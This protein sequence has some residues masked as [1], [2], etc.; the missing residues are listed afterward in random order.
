MIRDEVSRLLELQD[1][2]KFSEEFGDGMMTPMELGEAVRNSLQ[3]ISKSSGISYNG[4]LEYANVFMTELNP[5]IVN[6]TEQEVLEA[7]S[8]LIVLKETYGMS[9]N[10]AC[11]YGLYITFRDKSDSE[12]THKL[13]KEVI[14][15]RDKATEEFYNEVKQLVWMQQN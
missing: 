2:G 4:A 12:S 9:R 7:V 10:R 13:L 14:G 3:Q 8:P 15:L 1:S 11:C 5:H 6:D